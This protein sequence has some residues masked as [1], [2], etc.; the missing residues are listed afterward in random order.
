MN[1]KLFAHHLTAVF[2]ISFFLFHLQTCA[3]FNK[4]TS[5]LSKKQAEFSTKVRQQ[6]AK[7]DSS[8]S[9]NYDALP[10]ENDR[11]EKIIHTYRNYLFNFP[12]T[13]DFDFLYIVKSPDSQLVLVS[14]DTRMG[15][16]MIEFATIAVFKTA[17][18]I[19][20]FK[21]VDKESEEMS[22]TYMH[23]NTIHEVVSGKG[24]KIYLAWGN[25]QG[26]TL[27]P[28][29]EIR[30]FKISN[31][32]LSQPRIF[33]KSNSYVSVTF[34]LSKFNPNDQVPT[35][36]VKDKGRTIEVPIAADD[37]SFT[38]KYRIYAFNGESFIQTSR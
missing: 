26:S 38:G 36:K 3:Q 28:W 27:L 13:L 34:D 2:T 21:I 29:Q 15:G 22:N 31:G 5:T 11:L 17:G 35:I 37:D 14:W 10:V 9:G 18:G 1:V 23:Y 33:P 8:R 20:S 6:F 25:G 7:I 12:D 30:A 16:T 24:S 32:N 4:E 19:K